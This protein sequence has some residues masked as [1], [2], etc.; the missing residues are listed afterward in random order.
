MWTGLGVQQ[1]H[2]MLLAWKQ[3]NGKNY[4]LLSMELQN[5]QNEFTSK[6]VLCPV[7]NRV[8]EGSVKSGCGNSSTC[9]LTLVPQQTGSYT[10]DPDK[11]TAAGWGKQLLLHQYWCT[12]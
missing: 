8:W 10:T 1:C 12:L 11:E 5:K 4:P 6:L 3:T 7:L 9:H 2:C